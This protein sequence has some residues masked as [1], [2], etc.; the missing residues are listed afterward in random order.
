M[1]TRQINVTVHF[2]SESISR[3]PAGEEVYL[4]VPFAGGYLGSAA[5]HT[6][7]THLPP[8]SSV[9]TVGHTLFN[10][11]LSLSYTAIS[12]PLDTHPDAK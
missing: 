3:L 4:L 8:T 6:T 11:S 5:D 12:L 9:Q 2:H 10:F 1:L 7:R